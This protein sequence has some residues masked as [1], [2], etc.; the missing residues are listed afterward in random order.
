MSIKQ[1]MV[2]GINRVI[3]VTKKYS[4]EILTAVGIVAGIGATATAV[5][6]TLHCDSILDT[7][8]ANMNKIEMAKQAVEE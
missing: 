7:H 8:K 4:P 3:L 5:N 6:S 1:Q 2:L